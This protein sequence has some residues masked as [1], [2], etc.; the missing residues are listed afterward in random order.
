M[1]EILEQTVQYL[2]NINPYEAAGLIFGLLAV[3][4]LI[5]EN[6]WTWPAGIAYVLVSFV[7]FWQEKLYADFALHVF[8][9]ALNIYGW[10]YWVHGDK[11]K[12]EEVPVTNTPA[13]LLLLFI[14]ASFA[15][16]FLI[17][18]LLSRT[19]ASL[20]YWDS[21]TT[22]FSITAM[23]LT[24]RKKI[25]NWYFWFFVDVVATGV[26]FYKDIYFYAILYLIYI[27]LAISGYLAWKKT[28]NNQAGS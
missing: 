28:M 10:W 16:T 11:D 4:F 7:I 8:F 27:G 9:L 15:G 22:V 21:A 19:D 2:T 5:R 13:S 20:P 26:Y 18:Y 17:G 6:I 1:H 14:V 23:W 3:V 25:E 24:A 12:E